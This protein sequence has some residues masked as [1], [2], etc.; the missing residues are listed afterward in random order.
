MLFQYYTIFCWLSN[1]L[2]QILRDACGSYI[3]WYCFL[4]PKIIDY[5]RYHLNLTKEQS[6]IGYDFF[7]SSKKLLILNML[8]SYFFIPI[9]LFLLVIAAADDGRFHERK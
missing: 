4:Y 8:N 9:F 6:F 7:F 1:Q 3:V 5:I 2:H